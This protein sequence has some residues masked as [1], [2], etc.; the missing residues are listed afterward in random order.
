MISVHRFQVDTPMWVVAFAINAFSTSRGEN[1]KQRKLNKGNACEVEIKLEDT[2]LTTLYGS[3]KETMAFLEAPYYCEF[4]KPVRIAPNT[5]YI[6]SVFVQ[7]PNLYCYA[8]EREKT[9][10]AV[11]C[12]DTAV[13]FKFQDANVVDDEATA[14]MKQLHE[15]TFMLT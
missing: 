6:A 3:K 15:I 9:T 8:G 13:N 10:A 2:G 7:G 5:I 14:Q 11:Q 4:D 1:P 12:E